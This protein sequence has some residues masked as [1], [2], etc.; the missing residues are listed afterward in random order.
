MQY[1]DCTSQTERERGSKG[2]RTMNGLSGYH[3]WLVQGYGKEESLYRCLRQQIIE[4]KLKQGDALPSTREAARELSLSRGTVITAYDRLR[5]EGLAQ[6]Q[7]GGYTTVAYSFEAEPVGEQAAPIPKLSPFGDRIRQ[8]AERETAASSLSPSSGDLLDL[9]PHAHTG[10]EVSAHT[11]QRC[12][13]EAILEFDWQQS[14]NDHSSNRTASLEEAIEL[15]LMRHRGIQTKRSLIR[16]TRGSQEA[17]LLLVQAL[18]RTGDHVLI[19]TPG[20]P[21]IRNIV[22]AAGGIPEYC[23]VQEGSSLQAQLERSHARLMILTPNRQFPTGATMEWEQ[24]SQVL[25][26][27][28]QN[29]A[30]II[31]DDF[32]SDFGLGGKRYELLQSMDRSE[33]VLYVGSFSRTIHPKLRLGYMVLPSRLVPIMDPMLRVYQ[34]Y[35]IVSIEQRALALFILSGSYERHLRRVSRLIRQRAALYSRQL[36]EAVGSLLEWNND[37]IGLHLYAT[38]T[39]SIASYE[40]FRERALSY[41]VCWKEGK[42]YD[43]GSG[44]GHPLPVSRPSVLFGIARLDEEQWKLGCDRLRMAAAHFEDHRAVRDESS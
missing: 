33:R 11:W 22:E 27:A 3:T 42:G 5:A 12:L 38:W 14:D 23:Q 29:D 2:G 21:G 39:G 9:S 15:H 17:I 26:W 20:Y 7:Q 1:Y 30:F 34:R 44:Y 6:A 13:R 19:E 43:L 41:G 36:A 40:S 31:E 25:R 32:D 37:H 28:E 35:E 16:V 8:L 4:G 10:L 24:R 18:V